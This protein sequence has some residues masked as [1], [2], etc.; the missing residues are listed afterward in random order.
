MKLKLNE[1]EKKIFEC[2]KDNG[3]QCI[4]DISSKV[5]MSKQTVSRY[6]LGLEGKGIVICREQ[7]PYKFYSIS[8]DL[9]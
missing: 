4:T 6:L 5:N 7:R 3:E 8:K 2:L 9:E 1:K